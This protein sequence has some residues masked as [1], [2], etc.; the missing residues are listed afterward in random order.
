MNYDEKLSKLYNEIIKPKLEKVLSDYIYYGYGKEEIIL[1]DGTKEII[2]L[3]YPERCYVKSC[4]RSPA[5]ML[6][7][8]DL[9]E[10]EKLTKDLLIHNQK[11]EDKDKKVVNISDYSS[12]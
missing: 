1:P 5:E 12:K 10:I 9:K 8:P 11:E 3:K 6:Q 4:Y 2:E 7:L